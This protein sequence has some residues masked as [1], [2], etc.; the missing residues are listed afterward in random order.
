MQATEELPTLAPLPDYAGRSGLFDNR[1]LSTIAMVAA[2]HF[3]VSFAARLSGTVLYAFLGPFYVFVDGIGAEAV[4]CLLVAV[5]VTL[6]PRVG[7]A[8]LTIATVFLLNGIVSGSLSVAAAALVLVSIVAHEAI[9]FLFGVTKRQRSEMTAANA[10]TSLLLR[11]AAAV[12]LAN[13]AA[14]YGQFAISMSFYDLRFAM[15]YV[16]AVALIT[17][18]VYGAVGAVI[19]TRWGFQLRKTAP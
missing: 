8:T 1:E 2:L 14:L 10:S 4:P 15:W 5:I 9:L 7:T 17:G 18:V 11:T 19:G 13:G 16:H 6:I 3:V 12:G